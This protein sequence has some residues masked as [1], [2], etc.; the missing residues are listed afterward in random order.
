MPRAELTKILQEK[1]KWDY[2]AASR[3]IAFGPDEAGPNVLIDDTISDEVD[4]ASLGVVADQ[5]RKSFRWATKEGPL[6]DER[7]PSLHSP[8]CWLYVDLR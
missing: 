3:I 4:R 1:Y 8:I 6:C 5:L 2:L 7:K